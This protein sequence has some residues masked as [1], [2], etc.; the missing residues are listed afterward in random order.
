MILEQP[1]PWYTILLCARPE[2]ED[3]GRLL[4]EFQLSSDDENGGGPRWYESCELGVSVYILRRKVDAIQFFSSEH[5]DFRG[6]PGPLPLGLSFEMTREEVHRRLGDPDDFT[7]ARDTGVVGHAGVDRYYSAHCTVAVTYS[8]MSGK[9][10][11]L[12]FECAERRT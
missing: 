10:E 2:G 4:S 6:F 5:P 12:G 3:F 8:A 1:M 7:G 9:V 11:V